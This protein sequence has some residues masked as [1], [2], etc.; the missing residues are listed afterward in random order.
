MIVDNVVIKRDLLFWANVIK[1]FTRAI[2]NLGWNIYSF[3][4]FKIIWTNQFNKSGC[5]THDKSTYSPK[6]WWPHTAASRR[7]DL[8]CW[9]MVS[10]GTE[11]C[12]LTTLGFSYSV[13]MVLIPQQLQS[14]LLRIP[15]EPWLWSWLRYPMACAQYTAGFLHES[16]VYS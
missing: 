3:D 2:W 13:G 16:V 10:E 8:L 14:P 12:C 5:D 6:M 9:H 4:I 11:V 15:I 1:S 7:I